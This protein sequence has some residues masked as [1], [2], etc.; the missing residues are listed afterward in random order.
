MT[1]TNLQKVERTQTDPSFQVKLDL[2][3][4]YYLL[5]RFGLD[6]QTYTHLSARV[7]GEDA[8]YIYPFGLLFQEVTPHN[9]L[10]VSLDGQVLEGSEETY[11]RT[12]YV[13]HG[14]VYQD[15]PEINAVFHVHTIAGVAVSSMKWGLLPLSQFSYIFY[16]AL[17]R[18][19][20]D[21]L[22]LSPEKQGEDITKALGSHKALLLENHG[23]LT[24]GRDVAEAFG[25][26]RFLENACQ[27]QVQALQA[28]YDN[29]IFPDPET[30]KKARSDML[31]FEEN[32]GQRDFQ[33][34]C[35][36]TPFPFTIPL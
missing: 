19:P 31:A 35:R 11:N 27:V 16:E 5:S 14:A 4:A 36:A 20:Y 25:L 15:R 32:F 18:Y 1:P 10:K 2:A 7:P 3:K 23:T 13:I 30:C 26:L 21:S 33:A 22:A 29:L 8:Y 17:G 6:D 34:Y 24:C 9:L 12:G 28:G